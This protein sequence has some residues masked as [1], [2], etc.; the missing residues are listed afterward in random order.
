MG[1][2][3]ALVEFG[4]KPMIEHVTAALAAAGL[5][6]LVV[7]RAHA[8]GGFPAIA[9]IADIGG[10]PAVGLLTAFRH[11]PDNDVL[12]V[13]VDQPQIRSTTIIGILSQAGD[14]VV[15]IDSGHPQVTCALYRRETHAAVERAI[16]AGRMKLRRILDDVDTN[17]VTEPTWAS[18][19]E[20]GRSWMSL[21]T[22]EAVR[23]AEALR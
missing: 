15:P 6:L 18:W 10:G 11:R 8:P 17:Y 16:A 13:A 7:G 3:K 21:D 20:D 12:L 22:P 4:G 9:D 1:A 19:G 2:D 5:D 23:T 14:A